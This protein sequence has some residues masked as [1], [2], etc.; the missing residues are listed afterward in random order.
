MRTIRTTQIRTGDPDEPTLEA[1]ARALVH[2]VLAGRLYQY[3]QLAVPLTIQLSMWGWWRCA[4]WSAVASLFGAW[5][6]CD[7]A[8]ERRVAQSSATAAPEDA[9]WLRVG[10]AIAGLAGGL[11][12]SALLLEAFGQLMNAMLRCFGC[13]R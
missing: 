1:E 6:L 9:R 3:L 13:A 8:L 11:T 4:G 7:E 5:G 10:R 2:G 12:A